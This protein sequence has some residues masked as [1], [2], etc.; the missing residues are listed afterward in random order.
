MTK[1]GHPLAFCTVHGVFPARGFAAAPGASVSFVGCRVDCPRCGAMS[2]VIPGRYDFA[3]Q[4]LNLLLDPTITPAALTAI[5][6]LALRVKQGEISPE[7]AKKQAAEIFPAAGRL[8]DVADWSGQAKATLCAGI[9][10]AVALVAAAKMTSGPTHMTNNITH[11]V[12]RTVGNSTMNIDDL[13][14]P[15]PKPKPPK[16][17]SASK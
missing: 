5:R 10:T 8:F 15:Q 12:E 11:V 6:Q 1:L 14:I 7:D 13:P 17:G 9:I 16:A 2:E 3:T 4:G